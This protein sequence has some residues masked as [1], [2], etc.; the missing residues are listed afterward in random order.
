MATEAQEPPLSETELPNPEPRVT[1][2]FTD[3]RDGRTY[4]TVEL[5]G[6]TWMAENLNF[7]V[8]EECWF[9]DNDPKNGAKYGRLY[10]WEAA[11]RACPPGWRLLTDRKHWMLPI[12]EQR[13]SEVTK[14]QKH[15]FWQPG[16]YPV[17]L[18]TEKVTLQKIS[19]IHD[20][21]VRA[22]FVNA[23][24]EYFYSSAHPFQPLELVPWH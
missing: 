11:Q 6:L 19:Y 14:T 12:F 24:E 15:Q 22:G 18:F 4:R 21:P 16:N 5:N 7:D 2:S 20:N 1:G 3:P 17:H 9:Y 8:G 23:P 10:T 13:G